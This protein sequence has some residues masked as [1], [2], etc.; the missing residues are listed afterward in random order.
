[1]PAEFGVWPHV[2]GALGLARDE[3]P[4]SGNTE[5]YICLEPRPHLDGRYAVFGLL[6][7]GE[8]VLQA[9]GAVEVKEQWD[10][11]VAFHRP[12]EPVTIVRALLEKRAVSP[13]VRDPG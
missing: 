12:K 11:T 9:I 10:G 6:I 8:D 7:E 3:D 1:V 13:L 2:V 5:I 4:A